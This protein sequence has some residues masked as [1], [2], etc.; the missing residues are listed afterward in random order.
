MI[1]Q[2]FIKKYFTLIK[3]L[4]VFFLSCNLEMPIVGK[5]ATDMCYDD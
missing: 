4:S 3:K 5:C 2:L 1:N